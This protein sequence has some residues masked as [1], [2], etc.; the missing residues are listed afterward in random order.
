M[1]NASHKGGNIPMSRPKKVPNEQAVS[2]TVIHAKPPAPTYSEPPRV[3]AG[4]GT[5]E[6]SDK[7]RGLPPGDGPFV[8][9]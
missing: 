5:D 9:D 1:Y 7:S 4:L 8:S 2:K 6:G 3:P